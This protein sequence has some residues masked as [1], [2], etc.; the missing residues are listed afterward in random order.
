MVDGAFNQMAVAYD[1][2]FTNS[3]IGKLQRNKVWEYL[4]KN[5]QLGKTTRVLELNC[6]TGEDALT[7]AQKGCNITATDISSEMINVARAKAEKANIS[8]L[9]EF[10]ILNIDDIERQQF[11]YKYDLVFSNF[12]GLNCVTKSTLEKLNRTLKSILTSK[13]RLVA[14]VMPDRCMMETTYFLLKL[15]ISKAFRRGNKH[16]K[17]INDSGDSAMIYYYSPIDFQSAFENTFSLNAIVPV[18]LWV[19]P[20]YTENFF[21]KHPQLLNWLSSMENT[22]S[23][24]CMS[25]IS[26]HYLI[27]LQIKNR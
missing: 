22:C 13:G 2:V 11:E 15:Q 9:I 1:S 16:V 7:F 5:L 24:S 6:G 25:R 26:D 12:G 3:E 10:D 4:N 21:Q 27:D 20:S 18:G 19:P 17:W 23:P 14:V 8:G